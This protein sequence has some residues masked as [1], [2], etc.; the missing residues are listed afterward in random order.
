MSFYRCN[1]NAYMEIYW[2]EE[3]S[4]TMSNTVFTRESRKL[5]LIR[6]PTYPFISRSM[7][8]I[9]T[10]INGRSW[11]N[12]TTQKTEW[13]SSQ[14]FLFFYLS[15]VLPFSFRNFHVIVLAKCHLTNRWII[16]TIGCEH[17]HEIYSNALLCWIID[18]S[19]WQIF[20]FNFVW[21]KIFRDAKFFKFF[22][23]ESNI[24]LSERHRLETP[25][26]WWGRSIP[27]IFVA[28]LS[29]LQGQL[30]GCSKGRGS[31]TV[32]TERFRS[33]TVVPLKTRCGQTV[34]SFAQFVSSPHPHAKENVM[35][36]NHFV[37]GMWERVAASSRSI[38][39]R[40]LYTD[41]G[42]D[43]YRSVP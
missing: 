35:E 3:L 7:H 41:K 25:T 1:E 22:N 30:R 21:N 17:D 6:L 43:H 23:N 14:Y 18:K 42:H 28:E 40:S 12:P 13:S 29:P 19:L 16:F 37:P 33:I 8:N 26:F 15:C 32:A 24:L 34:F 31:V 27:P 10:I 39:P 4:L 38:K 36:D 2:G 11:K 9:M 5:S 20:L